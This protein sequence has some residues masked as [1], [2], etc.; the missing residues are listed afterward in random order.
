MTIFHCSVTIGMSS[1]R[2]LYPGIHNTDHQCCE[3]WVIVVIQSSF[4][5]SQNDEKL[6]NTSPIGR[7]GYSGS[8]NS[9]QTQPGNI[10]AGSGPT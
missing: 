9:S 1:E 4:R 5:L 6:S 2:P 3:F 8:K 7:Y 10:D